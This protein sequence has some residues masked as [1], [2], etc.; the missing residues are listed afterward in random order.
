MR[1]A[2]LST[3]KA[4]VAF[5]NDLDK[6]RPRSMPSPTPPVRAKGL[7][8]RLTA[9]VDIPTPHSATGAQQIF[10]ILQSRFNI[11]RWVRRR[12]AAT[13]IFGERTADVTDSMTVYQENDDGTAARAASCG[14]PDEVRGVLLTRRD[15][16]DLVIY[17]PHADQGS[18]EDAIVQF[19]LTDREAAKVA[20]AP[21]TVPA[22]KAVVDEYMRRALD[23]GITRGLHHTMETMFN[24]D[25][26]I[27]FEEQGFSKEEMADKLGVS[28]ATL[29]RMYARAGLN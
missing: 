7:R 10:E 19:L 21:G 27:F 28:R 12:G 24:K 26:L 16:S 3:V 20:D 25:V 6:G 8:P 18:R 4:A 14:E 2:Q 1:S 22:R 5:L 23:T 29:Y 11:A 9:A 15:G 17:H 13:E